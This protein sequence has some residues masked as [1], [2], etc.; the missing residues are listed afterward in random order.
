MPKGQGNK[1]KGKAKKPK[2]ILPTIWSQRGV[3]E[4]QHDFDEPSDGTMTFLKAKLSKMPDPIENEP[5]AKDCYCI[6][7]A[8]MTN[9]KHSRTD[10]AKMLLLESNE[11]DLADTIERHKSKVICSCK[12]ASALSTYTSILSTIDGVPNEVDQGCSRGSP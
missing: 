7:G 9:S 6:K 11:N 5:Y 3:V 1:G 12:T 2:N 8:T 4:P 10:A